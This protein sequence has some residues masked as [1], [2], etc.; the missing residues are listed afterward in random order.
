M[1]PDVNTSQGRDRLREED[2]HDPENV[3][4]PV[5][6]ESDGDAGLGWEVTL[7]DPNNPFTSKLV[8][9]EAGETLLWW[10]LDPLTLTDLIGALSAVQHAQVTA[11]G[12]TPAP[13]TVPAAPTSTHADPDTSALA[14]PRHGSWLARHKF[15]A[16]LALIVALALLST[17]I[18]GG[19]QI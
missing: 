9:T 7:D 10:G 12:G 5:I 8:F 2:G 15:L 3:L 11:M 14:P 18:H 17:V 1:A 16:A 4:P 6:T 13:S 19:S